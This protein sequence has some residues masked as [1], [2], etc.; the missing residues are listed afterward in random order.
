MA[1]VADQKE[2]QKKY[3]EASQA[4]VALTQRIQAALASKP[5]DPKGDWSLVGSMQHYRAELQEICD[6]LYGEGEYAATA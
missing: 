1:T 5:A 3:T 2:C 4:A 6:A